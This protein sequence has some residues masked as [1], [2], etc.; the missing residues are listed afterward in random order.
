MEIKIREMEDGRFSAQY[1]NEA[2]KLL[3]GIEQYGK[4]PI[5]AEINLQ[6]LINAVRKEQLKMTGAYLNGV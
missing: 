4:S 6:T 5:E 2:D 1:I 3:H